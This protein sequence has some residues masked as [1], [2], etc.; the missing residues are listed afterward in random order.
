[1]QPPPPQPPQCVQA[2]AGPGEDSVTFHAD[3]YAAVEAAMVAYK[4][5]LLRKGSRI[6]A[7]TLR[8]YR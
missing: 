7:P 6:P 5:N 4:R 3:S 8:A 2:T 1:V